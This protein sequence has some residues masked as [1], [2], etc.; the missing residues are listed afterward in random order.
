MKFTLKV[1]NYLTL[2]FKI[3]ALVLISLLSCY[4]SVSLAENFRNF[5]GVYSGEYN[6]KKI[7]LNRYF[8]S[9]SDNEFELI[10]KSKSPMIKFN[11]S[12]VFKY[13]GQSIQSLNYKS[14]IKY[15]PFKRVQNVIFDWVTYSAKD[16]QN[17]DRKV[18][19]KDHK[20]ILDPLS[21]QLALRQ[22]VKTGQKKD[23]KLDVLLKGAVKRYHF[24]ILPQE[25]I[26][27]P[28]GKFK[29]IPVKRVYTSK[30]K[31]QMLWFALDYDFV[32]LKLQKTDNKKKHEVFLKKG[33]LGVQYIK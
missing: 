13:K 8:R 31:T 14:Y 5:E 24:K 19:L 33:M 22:H 3:Q 21:Y 10:H 6:G 1:E 30:D 12:S 11:E 32:L 16:T 18:N 20:A 29:A 26:T 27:T 2:L 7:V 15:G 23:L 9:K 17:K 4:S 28:L 25:T